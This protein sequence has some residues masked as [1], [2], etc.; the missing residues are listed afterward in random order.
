MTKPWRWVSWLCLGLRDPGELTTKEDKLSNSN[1]KLVFLDRF[2]VQTST[3][4]N[5]KAMADLQK[6]PTE[7]VV[8]YLEQCRTVVSAQGREHKAAYPADQHERK[9]GHPEEEAR[10]L[11]PHK[12][13]PDSGAQYQGS[14]LSHKEKVQLRKTG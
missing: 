3:V 14:A 8:D 1:F 10:A 9:F 12:Q 5:V 2:S 13:N 11:K 7:R 6:G 4:E